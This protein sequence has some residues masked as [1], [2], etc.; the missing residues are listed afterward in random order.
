MDPAEI[1]DYILR[2]WSK[3]PDPEFDRAGKVK[4]DLISTINGII[5]K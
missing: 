3:V 2:N 5:E 4:K 1:V